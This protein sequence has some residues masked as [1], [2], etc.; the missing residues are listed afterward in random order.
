MATITKFEDLL[1]WQIAGELANE[2]YKYTCKKDFSKDFSL[3]DQIRRSSGSVMDNIAEGFER[4]GNK[5]FNHF[6]SIAKGSLGETKSQSYRAKDRK[7][8]SDIEFE[9]IISLIERTGKLVG[10]LMNYLSGTKIKGRK[11]ME[12]EEPYGFK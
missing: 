8:L 12:P 11:F 4:D 6:L 2:V 7:Y 5:E 10:G 3:V 1:A 9:E